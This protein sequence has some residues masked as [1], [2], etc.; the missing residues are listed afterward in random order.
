MSSIRQT[1]L[2]LIIL[3]SC[4]T[5]CGGKV[6]AQPAESLGFHQA[7]Q[8][9][10][11]PIEN[12]QATSFQGDTDFRSLLLGMFFGLMAVMAI[13]NLLLYFS[14]K[15]KAYLLYVGTVVFNILTTL[16]ING[17]GE[18]YFW[19]NHEGLDSNCP[20]LK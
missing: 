12:G 16:A 7:T 19:P 20:S 10:A 1:C 8:E 11:L 13:Y 18:Q 5:F 15:D 14:L 2:A 4:V 17:L 6:D 3:I 9:Q